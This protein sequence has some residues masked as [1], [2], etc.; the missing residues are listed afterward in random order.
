MWGV[1]VRVGTHI[2][3]ITVSYS[4]FR[5]SSA[6]HFFRLA[7]TTVIVVSRSSWRKLILK[8]IA[9][10]SDSRTFKSRLW[11]VP[12]LIIKCLRLIRLAQ[13]KKEWYHGWVWGS[14]QPLTCSVSDSA[15]CFWK[16]W[17]GATGQTDPS[18]RSSF[19]CALNIPNIPCLTTRTCKRENEQ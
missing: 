11:Q 15:V 8:C 9:I 12:I 1:F 3:T 14:R 10:Q 6:S 19:E 4:L 18:A 13:L 16:F 17:T 2:W 7:C 5:Y